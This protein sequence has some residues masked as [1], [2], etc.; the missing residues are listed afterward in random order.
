MAYTNALPFQSAITRKMKISPAAATTTA[1]ANEDKRTTSEQCWD[2][3]V[4][5][6][7]GGRLATMLAYRKRMYLHRDQ[8]FR[9]G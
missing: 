9:S 6:Q 8:G 4:L 7:S 3:S 1:T 2:C 5:N